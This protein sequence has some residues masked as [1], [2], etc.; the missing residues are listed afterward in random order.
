MPPAMD[1]GCYSTQ[2]Q[3]LVLPHL[4]N[5]GIQRMQQL[6]CTA[7]YWP[8]ID[9]DITNQCQTCAEHQTKPTKSRGCY[10]RNS[11]TESTLIM[12]LIFWEPT[13]W[14]WWKPI[15]N[16]HASIP[17]LQRQPKPPQTC[18]SRTLL[19]LGTCTQLPQTVLQYSLWRSFRHGVGKMALF[20]S[21]VHPI[22]QLQMEQWSVSYRLSN[23]LL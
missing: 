22:N 20:T 17:L 9:T 8:W 4:G 21:Q 3:V 15:P 16:T 18:W 1:K 14:Y 2:P 6:A 10:R 13:G 19:I 5:L 11:G 12:Q 7:V 23:K